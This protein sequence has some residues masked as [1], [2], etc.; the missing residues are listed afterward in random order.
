MGRP[1]VLPDFNPDIPLILRNNFPILLKR[2]EECIRK[3]KSKHKFA[4]CAWLNLYNRMVTR[5][6]SAKVLENPGKAIVPLTLSEI[7]ALE[8]ARHK[9]KWNWETA[10]KQEVESIKA[11]IKRPRREK[12]KK[13]N[14]Q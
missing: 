4:S 9:G 3:T 7:N 8:W 10:T 2:A 6:F 12:Q 1:R 14:K 5:I 11:K 13:P